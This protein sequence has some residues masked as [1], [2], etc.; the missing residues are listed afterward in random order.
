MSEPDSLQVRLLNK[1]LEMRDSTA[2]DS[3]TVRKHLEDH[4]DLPS[5]TVDMVEQLVGMIEGFTE[6][7]IA[8]NL[9][10]CNLKD[11]NARLAATLEKL[12]R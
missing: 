10:N 5:E 3:A 2:E 9:V 1:M 4:P 7:L 8:I 12:S 11:V 6:C